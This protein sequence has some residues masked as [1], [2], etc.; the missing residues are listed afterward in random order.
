[1]YP[2]ALAA[3]VRFSSSVFVLNH[4]KAV[5]LGLKPTLAAAHSGT[6]EAVPFLRDLSF[7]SE[8]PCSS[9]QRVFPQPV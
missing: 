5:P 2:A 1:M 8:G 9:K 6:A 4:E 7:S 3:E